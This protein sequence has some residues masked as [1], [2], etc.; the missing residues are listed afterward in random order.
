MIQYVMSFQSSLF[1]I[2]VFQ[3]QFQCSEHS[4]LAV[5][6]QELLSYSGDIELRVLTAFPGIL[7]GWQKEV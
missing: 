3:C 5:R 6:L 2:E 1:Y 4:C 7:K